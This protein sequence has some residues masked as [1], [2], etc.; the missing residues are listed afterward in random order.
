MGIL[1]IYT[2]HLTDRLGRKWPISGGMW[3]AAA[4]IVL[5]VLTTTLMGWVVGAVLMG[6]G[7]ALLYPTLLAA[8]SDVA[9]PRWRATSLGVYR[10]W[11]D[12]G[13]AF[14][15]LAIGII[16]DAF[17]LLAGFWFAAAIM[18]V[19]GLV[20]ALL[21]YETLP[22]RRVVQLYVGLAYTEWI[23]TYGMLVLLA[24]VL[25]AVPAGRRLGIDL[26]LAPRLQAAGQHHR[27]ARIASWFV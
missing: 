26:W 27:F 14:G 18:G 21:M 10:L 7:M 17:G 9:A 25:V 23:W 11:R 5:V 4:G 6:V 15:A 1:Q 22:S 8:V 3:L 13:Y 2:G 20:V 16:A 19:S 12:S 24:L